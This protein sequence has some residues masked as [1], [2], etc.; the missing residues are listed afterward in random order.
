VKPG[1]E[2]LGAG[3]YC[4]KVIKLHGSL[5]WLNCPNCQRTYVDS[6]D[7]VA[8][9]E[10]TSC[11]HCRKNGIPREIM[12]EPN[13]IMPTYLK[14][15]SSLQYKMIWHQ[16]ANEL[17]EASRV[18]FMGYSLPPADFE[19]RQMLTRMVHSSAEIIMVTKTEIDKEKKDPEEDLNIRKAKKEKEYNVFFGRKVKAFHDGVR[20]YVKDHLVKG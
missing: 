7:K 9:R 15:L 19:I 16:A 1:L 4:I 12:L 10:V 8:L 3:G 20:S 5:N 11:R 17:A 14:D 2:V 13:V 18:V 6:Q